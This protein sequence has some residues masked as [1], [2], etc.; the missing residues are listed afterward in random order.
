MEVPLVYGD[1]VIGVLGVVESRSSRRFS[2]EEQALLRLF[3]RPAAAAI[4]NARAYRAQRELAHRT[5]ALLDSSRAV[6]STF[7]LEQVLEAVAREAAQLIGCPACSIYEYDA[8]RDGMISRVR[9]ARPGIDR[10]WAEPIGTFEASENGPDDYELMVRGEAVVDHVDDPDISAQE[11]EYMEQHG[12]SSTLSAPLRFGDQ[13]IG[14]LHLVELGRRREFT[15]QELELARAFGELAS[16][17]IHNARLFRRQE[18]LTG[19]LVGLFD[20]SRSITAALTVDEVVRA[21]YEEVQRLLPEDEASAIIWIRDESGEPTPYGVLDD[22]EASR[23]SETAV[24]AL[25]TLA[26]AQ[27][28]CAAGARLAIPFAVRGEARGFIEIESRRGAFSDELVEFLQIVVH[29]AAVAIENSGLYALVQTQAITDGLTGLFNHRYFYERLEQECARARRYDLPLALLMI[30]IDDFKTF[31]DRC[32][33]QRGDKVLRDVAGILQRGVRRGVDLPTRYGGE[34]FAILLPHTLSGGAR[35][36]RRPDHPRRRGAG[37]R[38]RRDPPPGAGAAPRRRA[39]AS[40]HRGVRVRRSREAGSGTSDGQRGGR[41]HG[42]RGRARGSA[43]AVRRQGSVPGQALGQEPRRGVLMSDLPREPDV[44]ALASDV[45]LAI[46]A[47]PDLLEMLSVAARRVAEALD[48]AEAAINTYD[49]ANDSTTIVAY[50]RRDPEP[51]WE[52]YLG[53]TYRLIDLPADREM[54]L[55]GEIVEDACPTPPWTS[56]TVSG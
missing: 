3:A 24:R 40:R 44:F 46:A 53:R 30:D 48:T 29:H 35:N 2:D 37:R 26:P 38:R 10:D 33:H 14:V 16:A 18:R 27:E 4:G 43:R 20:S 1:E 54:L 17:A 50:D 21:L 31:N 19:R 49:P 52:Q 11:R 34:E 55:S 36:G 28:Q 8:E 5:A 51:G 32:G 25:A 41:G 45:G 56:A 6:A 47:S 13:P 7:V 39:A 22:Q 12:E 15:E 42:R 23:L 9:Y